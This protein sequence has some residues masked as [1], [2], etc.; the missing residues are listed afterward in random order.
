M[1]FDWDC[2]I[3]DLVMEHSKVRTCGGVVG[4]DD[5][6]CVSL[7]IGLGFCVEFGED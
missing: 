2:S 6:P 5:N 1:L 4:I 3:S 7:D